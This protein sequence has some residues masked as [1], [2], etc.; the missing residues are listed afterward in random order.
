MKTRL[1]KKLEIFFEFLIFGILMGVTEDL[2]AIRATTDADF[3]LRTLWVVTLVAIPFA[4][5]GELIVD[6]KDEITNFIDQFFQQKREKKY[7]KH[8][9]TVLPNKK[10]KK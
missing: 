2:I 6:K 9:R 1:R 10:S 8:P 5:F 7:K 4:I 3:T